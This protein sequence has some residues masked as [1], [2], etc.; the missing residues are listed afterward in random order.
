MVLSAIFHDVNHP[1][2]PN[3]VLVARQDPLAIHYQNQSVAEQN[4]F[5]LAWSL[6]MEDVFCDLR[7]AIYSTQAELDLF[8]QVLVN[9]IMATDVMDRNLSAR[10]N[11][12]WQEAFAKDGKNEDKHRHRATAV[13]ELI[14]QASDVA[15]TLQ[16]WPLFCTWNRRLFMEMHRAHM[17][18]DD[19]YNKDDP[20]TFWYQ[21][22]LDFFEHYVIRT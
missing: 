3:R 6:L 12:R 5:D 7:C 20:S 18:T 2:V 4:S 16:P 15:H 13:L 11:E 14:L 9:A 21:G 10:R 8:R 17:M 19:R 22:E 1:G